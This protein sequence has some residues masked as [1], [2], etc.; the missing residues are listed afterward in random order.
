MTLRNDVALFLWGFMAVW[1]AMLLAFTW[2]FW[3]DG[4]PPGLAPALSYAVLGLFWLFGLGA[5]RWAFAVRR[6]AVEVRPD[7]GVVL[8]QASPLRRRRETLSR[9]EIAGV[10]VEQGKDSEGDP[11]F[12]A[13]LVLRD[14]RRVAVKEGHVA[15][16]IEND[17]RRLRQALGVA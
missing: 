14:G 12:T 1:W 6:N 2:L 9:A 17:A 5:A 13:W 15:Q 16:A 11:Y 7:G 8:D 10:E 4:A 3:R